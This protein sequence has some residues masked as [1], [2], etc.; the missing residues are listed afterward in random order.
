MKA[1]WRKSRSEIFAKCLLAFANALPSESAEVLTTI[2]GL[3]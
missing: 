3:L 1:V 2:R